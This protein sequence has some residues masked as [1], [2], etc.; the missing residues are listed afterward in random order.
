MYRDA[1]NGRRRVQRPYRAWT[2]R[3]ANAR[4][5]SV[6]RVWILKMAAERLKHGEEQS[7]AK[8]AA[9]SNFGAECSRPWCKKHVDNFDY[10]SGEFRDVSD[11]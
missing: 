4:G 2:R 9:A 5:C 3:A 7:P 1:N 10:L 11:A 6:E 8:K